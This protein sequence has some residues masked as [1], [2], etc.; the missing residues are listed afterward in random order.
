MRAKISL[1]TFQ[2]TI[3]YKVLATDRNLVQLITNI[4]GGAKNER[5]SCTI[6]HAVK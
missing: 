3:N 5:I 6:V 4:Q 1:S 2:H